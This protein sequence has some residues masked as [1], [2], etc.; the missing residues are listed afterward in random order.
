MLTVKAVLCDFGISRRLERNG[1]TAI[2]GY[3]PV[4]KAPEVV[5]GIVAPAADMYSL[6]A[7]MVHVLY[8]VNEQFYEHA[9]RIQSKPLRDIVQKCLRLDPNERY[10]NAQSLWTEG[11][12]TFRWATV[13][14]R[15]SR[16]LK[17]RFMEILYAKKEFWK[18]V[19]AA[20]VG[21]FTLVING[22]GTA[23]RFRTTDSP[24]Q[25]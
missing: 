21:E 4:F 6:G 20:L 2:R 15:L 9:A 10:A 5:D 13:E 16:T 23:P 12:E 8:G 22:T 19:G 24:Q 25:G 18:G 7:T 1:T 17:D 14:E 3:H 11:L